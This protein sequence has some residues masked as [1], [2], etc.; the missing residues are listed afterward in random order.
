MK[1]RS[2]VFISVV[3]S[4]FGLTF[5]SNAGENER[6]LI[7]SCLAR[8]ANNVQLMQQ[9]TGLFVPTPV[10]DSC[11]RG[12][13]CFD[14]AAPAILPMSA[15][16]QM[17][18]ATMTNQPQGVP[19]SAAGQM[20][21]ATM[22]N[23]PQG[24]PQQIAMF[25]AQRAGTDVNAF[26]NC[27]RGQ[28]I[29]PES[30]Q[31][32]IDCAEQTTDAR[33]FANCAGPRI[34]AGK[35]NRD[36]RLAFDCATR[37]NGEVDTFANCMGDR[38]IAQ[39]L[40]TEQRVAIDCA[41]EARGDAGSFATCAGTRIIGPRLSKEQ[42]AAIECAAQ[43]H[44]DATGFAVCA[45]TKVLNAQLNPEQQIAVQC[46]TTTGGRPIGASRV[47]SLLDHAV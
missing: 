15:A 33:S 19:M 40:T 3:L 29:L 44:G 27:A 43:S 32:W 10:L 13:P 46:V 7:R 23:Q 11:I 24:S 2:L 8:G 25:C 9:C 14:A 41:R 26:A 38:F 4:C 37:S 47:E 5:S 12:G 20:A 21:A 39:R 35:L 28:V 31:V 16:G 36:Q 45:G 34:L 17:A 30:Q 1:T 42:R 22:T 18:V 6:Q